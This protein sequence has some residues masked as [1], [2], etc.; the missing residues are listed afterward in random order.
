M[1]DF[2]ETLII[3]DLEAKMMLLKIWVFLRKFSVF[4]DVMQVLVTLDK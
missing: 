2:E 3:L 1:S 4:S